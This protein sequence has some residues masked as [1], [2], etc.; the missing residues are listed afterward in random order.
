MNI[1][2]IIKYLDKT[3]TD[4]NTSKVFAGL[5]IITLN[6]GSRF[7]TIKLSKS[8]EG[9][10]KYTFSKQI[11]IFAIVWMGTRDIYISLA[12]VILFTIITEYLCNEESNM[13][14]LSDDFKSYHMEKLDENISD[15]DIKKAK[16]VLAKAE[17]MEKEKTNELMSSNDLNETLYRL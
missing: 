3:I 16:E 15:D 11:L 7:V 17:K 14:C 13:C 6:I 5:M 9:Y 1:S 4:L 8:M 2:K 10:L 12:I